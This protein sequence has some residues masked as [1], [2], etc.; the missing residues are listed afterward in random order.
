MKPIRYDEALHRVFVYDMHG[1]KNGGHIDF[2]ISEFLLGDDDFAFGHFNG[3]F[4]R[5]VG[6]IF[7][8]LVDAH[9][10]GAFDDALASGEIRIL[11]GH[12]HFAC[13]A[14]LEEN[15]DCPSGENIRGTQNS[16]DIVAG[17][18]DGGV[19][20]LFGVFRPPTVAPIFMNDFDIPT[21]DG[22][23]KYVVLT[24]FEEESVIV[25]FGP[26]QPDDTGLAAFQFFYEVTGLEFAYT[27]VVEGEVEIE[28]AV[29]DETIV[30]KGGMP[31]SCASS[32]LLAMA[33]PSWGMITR[34]SIPLLMRASQSRI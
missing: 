17:L 14:F 31:A 22:G 11:T 6:Q 13:E 21:G 30:G 7:N 32:T 23:I 26:E 10:L 18:G 4:G 9:R 15:L 8:R 25:S 34:A 28:V 29:E 19:D 33:A 1:K 2:T 16:V 5:C 24:L 3:Q 20:G 27:D 12:Q